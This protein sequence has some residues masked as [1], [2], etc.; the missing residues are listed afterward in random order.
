M[1]GPIVVA[2]GLHKSFG[3]T[4]ALRGLDL[5]VP[6]GAVYGVLGPNGAG[7]TTAVRILS[8]LSDP[9]AGHARIA[10]YDVVREAGKVRTRIG[11]AGQHAAVDE[12]LT[13]RT[14]LRMFGRLSHLSRPEARHRADELLERFGLMEAAD[15]QVTGY[16]G[17]MRRRLD[18]ITSLIL[19]PE[20]LFLDEPTT[21][22][23]PR[24]RGEIWANV[25]ELVADG[26]TVLLTTQYLDEADQLADDIAVVDHGR[27]I[28]TGTPDE[29]KA[30]I[31]D[32]IDVELEDSSDLLPAAAV[33]KALAAGTDP[34]T[35]GTD[36][37]SVALPGGALRL[38][39]IV[40]ELDHAG[41][42]AADV[43]LRRPTLD[44]VFLRLTDRKD[45]AR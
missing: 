22:L 29:L 14:N 41:I 38:Y 16:S 36:R 9:D 12:K 45:P 19:R 33:L 7:K 23:D 21:G 4:H 8:T 35:T 31:G 34:T 25:R 24:S 10:G 18:L 27:V 43:R 32:H 1:P 3:D 13:G 2:E 40:R 6:R 20:V 15:R 42:A 5:S 26:T 28:A 39:D 44:E 37:L 11:L 30:T 17:G